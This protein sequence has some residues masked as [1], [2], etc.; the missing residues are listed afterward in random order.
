MLGWQPWRMKHCFSPQSS[1]TNSGSLSSTFWKTNCTS[2]RERIDKDENSVLITF[3]FFTPFTKNARKDFS[4]ESTRALLPSSH[5]AM[6][7]DSRF[8][9]VRTTKYNRLLWI[10][11][12]LYGHFSSRNYLYT[13]FSGTGSLP[14]KRRRLKHMLAARKSS[15]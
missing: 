4:E 1:G 11:Y 6:V 8:H 15:N 7:S 2:E 13:Q 5:L 14:I 3:K 9:G 10:F 12:K